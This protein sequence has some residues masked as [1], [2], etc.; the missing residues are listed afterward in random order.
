VA[1]R[2]GGGGGVDRLRSDGVAVG[3]SRAVARELGLR[4][5]SKCKIVFIFINLNIHFSTVVDRISSNLI[6]LLFSSL[7]NLILY[8]S[9]LFSVFILLIRLYF[10]YN[11][12][13]NT[14]FFSC[15][16]CCFS[17][18]YFYFIFFFNCFI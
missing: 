7:T 11:I 14:I 12:P 17:S 15:L 10:Y 8:S 1:G 2:G 5:R 6:T 3:G 18:L 13:C 4:A 9:L 16:I